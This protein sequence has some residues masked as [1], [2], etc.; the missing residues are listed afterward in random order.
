MK[1]HFSTSFK[2]L[3][4]LA[5]TTLSYSAFSQK[6]KE[7]YKFKYSTANGKSVEGE[8]VTHTFYLMNVV[9]ESDCQSFANLLR[10]QDGVKKVRMSPV[11]AEQNALC[12]ITFSKK[13]SPELIQNLLKKV[14]IVEIII[15]NV[16]VPIDNMYTYLGNLKK[17]KQTK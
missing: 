8:L 15:D 12:A 5:F 10:A 9:E 1:K 3:L 13:F 6:Q 11:S 16:P 17:Q 2:A 4:I 7:S 14:G